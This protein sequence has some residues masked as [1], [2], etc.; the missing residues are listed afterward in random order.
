MKKLYYNKWEF[1]NAIN[2][3][4]SDPYEAKIRLEN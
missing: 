1:L 3:M 4:E 2:L